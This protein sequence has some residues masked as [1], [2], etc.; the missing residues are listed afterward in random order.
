MYKIL[1]IPVGQYMKNCAGFDLT[2]SSKEEALDSLRH[3]IQAI[4]RF[5]SSWN[6]Y[7]KEFPLKITEIEFEIEEI[8]ERV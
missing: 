2:Y 3:D 4:V 1:C 5:K 7:N 6:N 8:N